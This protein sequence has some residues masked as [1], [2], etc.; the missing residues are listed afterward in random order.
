MTL[1][2]PDYDFF[3]QW[4]LTERCNL[5]CTHCYQSKEASPELSFSE[6]EEVL[7]EIAE[8]M[9]AWQEKYAVN[10]S[11]SLSLTGGEPFLRH[12]FH[13]ILNACVQKGFDIYILSNGTL[14]DRELAKSLACR[15][16]KGVQV[17]MEGPEHIHDS[18][19]G[20]GSF[21]ASVEG[22]HHLLDSG[23]VVTLNTTLSALNADFFPDM[24]DLALSLGVQKLGF[25]RLVPSGRGAGLIDKM[26]DTVT[27]KEL[28]EKIF[29]LPSGTLKIVS[30]DPI[31]SHMNCNADD[32]DAGNIMTGGCAAGLS[33]FTLLADGTITP[34]RRLPV[35]LGNV[36]TDSLREVWAASPV[37][38]QLRDRRS[39][40]G[41]CG[42]CAKWA[43][44]RG[45]R[46]IAYAYA[47]TKDST[48]D[49]LADDPQCFIK[50]VRREP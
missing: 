17:S 22:V 42:Q 10:L 4:H 16:V 50:A 24:I 49:F 5:E 15:G 43:S 44:C 40:K 1:T 48:E 30:G 37:L 29:S 19:R 20:R 45:C 21:R 11:R 18:I 32:S 31:V 14:I 46:A 47:R 9:D 13:E 2:S 28:Y 34:C 6:I 7:D 3:V 12:D 38:E 33:G 26:L 36:K 8:M 27:V 35:S 39:Y 25:S 41:K 23:I